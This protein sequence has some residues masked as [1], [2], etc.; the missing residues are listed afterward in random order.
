MEPLRKWLEGQRY[1]EA[2]KVTRSAGL[3]SRVED[4]AGSAIGGHV[5]VE[6]HV[7]WRTRKVYV[8]PRAIPVHRGDRRA[9]GKMCRIAQ[10]DDEDEYE[11]EDVLKVL[12]VRKTTV[13][14]PK[15]CIE[16][17]EP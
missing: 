9:C 16:Q 15:V 7:S 6:H 11:D 13:M 8:C 14:D 17:V 3:L 2:V 5:E 1:L 4:V 10:G 12:E